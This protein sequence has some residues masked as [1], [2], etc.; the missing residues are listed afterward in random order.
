[1]DIQ[2]LVRE[3]VDKTVLE[4]K[5]YIHTDKTVII[6]G[7]GQTDKIIELKQHGYIDMDVLAK[8]LQH[9]A[10]N[11]QEELDEFYLK[12]R[13]GRI[14]EIKKEAKR[15]SR[16]IFEALPF[17]TARSLYCY[18]D[19]EM[20]MAEIKMRSEVYL[21]KLFYDKILL[22]LAKE[23]GPDKELNIIPDPQAVINK[24]KSV[25]VKNNYS[26]KQV[27]IAYFV[28]SEPIT[29]ENASDILK[30]HTKFSSEVKF[31][32][33]IIRSTKSLTTPT[34]N[35]TSNTKHLKNLLAAKRLIS[36]MKNKKAESA[37]DKYI[38]AFNTN[39][40]TAQ[41]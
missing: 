30:K 17:K 40:G 9:E 32:S 31:L 36:G 13:Q 27:A 21:W 28:M 23:L 12:Y 35:K 29:K 3:I 41:Q 8:G 38:Q 26:L 22:D 4:F 18:L 39:M 7:D 16:N 25:E 11:I 2:E 34:E 19:Q 15:K 10:L 24:K 14:K 37:I 1:M 6:K 20:L 33:K 5:P